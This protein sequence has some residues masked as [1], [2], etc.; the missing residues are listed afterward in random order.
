MA[1]VAGPRQVGKSTLMRGLCSAS[2]VMLNWDR[3]DDRRE[4]LSGSDQIIERRGIL[5]LRAAGNRPLV[6]FDEIHKFRQWKNFLKGFFDACEGRVSI[7]V[8]GSARLNVFKRGGDS[9]M[10]RYF[11]YRMHALSVGELMDRPYAPGLL[12]APG[13]IPDDQFQ[14]LYRFG[15]FPEPFL[16]GTERFYNRWIRLR[17]EQMFREELRDLTLVQDIDQLTTL[18]Q[19]LVRQAG[20]PTNYS[21]LANQVCVSVDT[22]RRWLTLLESIYYVFRV[23]PWFKN[24]AKSLR[25]Q[26]KVYPW[27][28]SAV[29]DPGARLESFAAAHLLKA[30]HWWTDLGLGRFDLHYIRDTAKREVD[31]LISKDGLPWILIEVKTSPKEPISPALKH[32]A[33]ALRVPH[34]FQAVMETES[35]VADCFVPDRQGAPFRVPLRTLCSQLP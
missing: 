31:F 16:R 14:A 21:A 24:V 2:D 10:G 19:M 34:A 1:F 12:R 25:K 18:S 9:L 7:L 30:V 22:I 13:E 29:Q 6:A 5:D 35:V 27:D 26:P 20:A 32:F 17:M 28:W 23:R 33:H 3:P 15:G 8:A 11:L 4:I